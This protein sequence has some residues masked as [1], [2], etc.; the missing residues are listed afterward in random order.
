[1]SN[2]Q[3]EGCPLR[4]LGGTAPLPNYVTVNCCADIHVGYERT[5]YTTPESQ[6]FVTL[7]AIIYSS[8][9]GVAPRPFAISYTTADDTAGIHVF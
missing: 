7:C 2:N 8:S 3:T 5:V 6:R 1:M 4:L 9:S